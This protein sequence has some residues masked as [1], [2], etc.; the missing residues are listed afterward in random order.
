MPFI[1]ISVLLIRKDKERDVRFRQIF[2]SKDVFDHAS[3][4]VWRS[5]MNEAR[6]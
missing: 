4:A 5:S 3:G 1:F 2:A 6:Q